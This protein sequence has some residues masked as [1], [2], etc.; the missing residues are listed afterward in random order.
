MKKNTR[1]QKG[2]SGNVS[3]QFKPGNQASK[4]FGRPPKLPKLDVYLAKILGEELKRV[5]SGDAINAL[6][7]ILKA[8][9][10]KAAKGDVKAATLLLERAYGKPKQFIEQ[11]HKNQIDLSILS[12]EELFLVQKIQAKTKVGEDEPDTSDSIS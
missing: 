8:L 3:T 11:V 9:R 10:A 12:E 2:K 5:D 4:G 6:E 7:V 1:F